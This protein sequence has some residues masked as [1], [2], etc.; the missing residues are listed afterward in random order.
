MLARVQELRVHADELSSGARTALWAAQ[1]WLQTFT[2]QMIEMMTTA[3]DAL[4]AMPADD[5]SRRLFEAY[6]LLAMTPLEP[7]G[8]IAE[9]DVLVPEVLEQV[10]REHD[11]SLAFIYLAR[12]IALLAVQRVEEA[13]EAARAAVRWVAPGT[14]GYHSALSHLLWMEYTERLGHG[15][16]FELVRDSSPTDFGLRQ[17]RIAVAISSDATVEVRAARLVALARSR[18]LGGLIYEESLF[19]VPF[20][21]LAIE[22]CD[23]DRARR[24]LDAFATIDPGSGTAG[25]RALEHLTRVTVGEELGPEG[26]LLHLFGPTAPDRLRRTIPAVLDDELAYWDVRLGATPDRGTG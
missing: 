17:I 1:V 25:V 10:T 20:A 26:V 6:R 7:D 3:I 9:T 4:A 21:W 8:V 5:P 18:P 24:L 22:E 15:P 13:R 11:Y 16:E 19:S 14:G 12:S 23:F 2:F